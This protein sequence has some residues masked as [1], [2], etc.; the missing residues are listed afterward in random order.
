[1]R[2]KPHDKGEPRAGDETEG[3]CDTSPEQLAGD[4]VDGTPRPY[5]EEE[6]RELEAKAA[7]R[8]E[9]LGKWQRKAADYINRE[10]RYAKEL[11]D[12]RRYAVGDFAVS[13]LAVLDNFER[14]LQSAQS[15]GD[16]D[17]FLQG[18]EMIHRDFLQALQR[19]GIERLEAEG[20]PF[21]PA[22][23]E[24]VA[25][26]PAEEVSPGTVVEVLQPGYRLHDRVIR[27]ARV[28]VAVAPEADEEDRTPSPEENPSGD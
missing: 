16:P 4:A 27:H 22:Y 24:A 13:L 14:A 23:H 10:R 21:D 3:A 26:V 19:A 11:G 6:L 7:E 5:T 12:L 20:A 8:D 2:R 15:S 28:M 17:S 1:M 18:V 9:C 25:Q